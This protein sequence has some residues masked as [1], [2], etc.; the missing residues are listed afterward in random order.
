MYDHRKQY[1]CD[2][3]RGKSQ[4]EMDDLL[5]AY[6]LVIDEICPCD[7][8]EFKQKFNDAF[9]RFLPLEDRTEKTFNNHRTEISGELFGMYYFS[10]NGMVYQ[11]ER[12]MRYLVDNDQPA[13][14]KDFVYKMQFPNGTQET[15]KTVLKRVSDGISIRPYA[16]LLRLLQ[17][18]KMANVI[19]TQKTVYYYV[20]N[21][22]DVLQGKADPFEVLEAI[23]SDQ[24]EGIVRTVSAIDPKTGKEKAGS[25]KTQHMRE[26]L[27]YLELANL[28]RLTKSPIDRYDK[29]IILNPDES[30]VISLIASQ[31]NKKPEFDVYAYDLNT[32]SGRKSFRYAWAEYYG[33]LSPYADEF[34]T[35]ITALAFTGTEFPS[36]NPS[37]VHVAGEHETPPS[38]TDDPQQQSLV[39]L[40]DEGEALIYEYEKKRVA[41]FNPHL[42][43]KVIPFGKTRGLGYDIQSVVALPGDKAEFVKYIEVKS[44]KRLTCPDPHD[45]LWIDT[46]NITRNEYVAALQHGEYYSIFR[47]Y[48]TQSGV[49][50]FVITNVGM[51]IGNGSMQT[52]PL[53]YRV[54]FSRGCV[55]SFFSIQKEA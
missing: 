40:G 1:R 39:E 17:L 19:I 36:E 6:A 29:S 15:A 34:K 14:F 53:T 28:I 54:D 35:S 44:T 10:E 48:F 38:E 12:T 43:R 30:T 55:D 47:V 24:H 27:N 2:I 45:E 13:F 41:A 18:A 22:L 11:S 3:I 16:F 4:K 31:W 8:T 52:T 50:V 49:Y 23:K 5:P 25:Y 20:L 37:P 46:F 21:S 26:M 51:K 7:K 33:K 32:K 9:S 42:A